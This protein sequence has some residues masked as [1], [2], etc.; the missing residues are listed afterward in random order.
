MISIIE[1]LKEV[2]NWCGWIPMCSHAI[3]IGYKVVGGVGSV[4]IL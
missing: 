2:S 3:R 1:L 4:L